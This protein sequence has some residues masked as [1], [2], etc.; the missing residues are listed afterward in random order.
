MTALVPRALFLAMDAVQGGT[1]TQQKCRCQE[2]GIGPASTPTLGRLYI[3]WNI[4]HLLKK[5]TVMPF[6]AMWMDVEIIILS[7]VRQADQDRHHMMSLIGGILKMVQ[8]ILF[9]KQN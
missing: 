2:Q 5:N 9:T 6:T 4:T 7:E 1:P 3:Q 8:T